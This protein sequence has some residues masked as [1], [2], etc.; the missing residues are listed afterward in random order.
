MTKL[1]LAQNEDADELISK[2]PLALLIGM[3]LDQ[4]ITIEKAFS[5]PLVLKQRL[6]HFPDA[7]EIADYDADKLI[8]VF[9]TPPAIHR[10]PAANAKRVQELCTIIV[11]EYEGDPEQIW[12]R[13]N[14]GEELYKNVLA[15]PGFGQRKAK[16]F[17]ALL[18]KQLD[19]QPSGWREASKPFGDQGVFFSVADITDSVT[20][21]KVRE[22]KK[23]EKA[24][25]K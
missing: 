4:Q 20:L 6:G 19:V 7:K 25:A 15:L 9:A 10:F 2:D 14:S 5:G 23:A 11:N 3:V 21:A 18:G 8:E 16:I 22:H 17:V 1:Q 13:A 12:K 24:K